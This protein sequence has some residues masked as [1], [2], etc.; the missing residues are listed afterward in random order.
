MS[1]FISVGFKGQWD[2]SGDQGVL[3]AV[4]KIAAE[5][6]KMLEG[7]VNFASTVKGIEAI[8]AAFDKIT[9]SADNVEAAMRATKRA[10]EEEERSVH[11]LITAYKFLDEIAS[12]PRSST[13]VGAQL[14]ME[15]RAKAIKMLRELERKSDDEAVKSWA[16]GQWERQLQTIRSINAEYKRAIE[17]SGALAKSQDAAA[18]AAERIRSEIV[19]VNKEIRKWGSTSLRGEG[20]ERQIAG[21][22]RL[23][24]L[25]KELGD[26][27]S[28]GVAEAAAEVNRYSAR[29]KEL[30]K[31]QAAYGKIAESGST[32]AKNARRAELLELDRLRQEHEK[33]NTSLANV[34][35]DGAAANVALRTKLEKQ[36]QG[37]I[38]KRIELGD[39]TRD[40]LAKEYEQIMRNAS[41]VDRLQQELAI[42]KA[43]I[44][45]PLQSE[46]LLASMQNRI[47][48]IDQA[49]KV[50]EQLKKVGGAD[51][52]TGTKVLADMKNER[53][54][55]DDQMKIIIQDQI[56]EIDLLK[57]E[58][59]VVERLRQKYNALRKDAA[60]GVADKSHGSLLSSQAD[61][62]ESMKTARDLY[63]SGGIDKG[64]Y[65]RE[66]AAIRKQLLLVRAALRDY[67]KQ[68]M[69]AS[70]TSGK[71]VK[72]QV[73]DVEKLRKK[74]QELTATIEKLEGAQAHAVTLKPQYE[75]LRTTL[76]GLFNSKD[77]GFDEYNRLNIE[78]SKRLAEL[79][80]QTKKAHKTWGKSFKDLIKYQF[81]WYLG[82]T[83]LLG[84]GYKLAEAF[85]K[86]FD[87]TQQ[88][89]DAKAVIGATESEFVRMQEAVLNVGKNIAVSAQDAAEAI[90]VL[91]QAGL[92]AEQAIS[93]LDTVAGLIVATGGD[94][95]ET[96]KSV[97]T[98]MNVWN[99]ESDRVAEIGNVMAASLN[100]S[101]LE[102][103]DLGVIFNYLASTAAEVNWT[104]EETSAAAAVLANQGIRVSTIG[105][106]LSSVVSSLIAPTTRM[107]KVFEE[108][109]LTMADLDPRTH[110]FADILEKL[111]EKGFGVEEAFR[112]FN[113]R[114]ARILAA[115]I[116][117]GSDAFREM[118]VNLTGTN[119][120]M[121]MVADSMA[122][123]KR[124]FELL[125]IEIQ[126][127][128]N[129]AMMD[130]ENYVAD[131]AKALRF[132][133]SAGADAIVP[134]T[135]FN[136]ALSLLAGTTKKTAD[137]VSVL[138][139][140]FT[141]IGGFWTL[142]AIAGSA[143]IAI[144]MK[145]MKTNEEYR[146]DLVAQQK[147]EMV[148]AEGFRQ[149]AVAMNDFQKVAEK[150]QNDQ[151]KLAEI[152]NRLIQ[153]DPA[154]IKYLNEQGISASET[155]TSY[156]ALTAAM[157]NYADEMR[158][159]QAIKEQAGWNK[160]A[161]EFGL[162][163]KQL[164]SLMSKQKEYDNYNNKATDSSGSTDMLD[165]PGALQEVEQK[166][167][168]L[169]AETAKWKSL[170][171]ALF[172]EVR[173]KARSLASDP[174]GIISLKETLRSAF[175]LRP[176]V[177]NKMFE[178]IDKAVDEQK[179]K[180]LKI[181]KEEEVAYITSNKGLKKIYAERRTMVDE[182]IDYMIQQ[183]SRSN[184]SESTVINESVSL[185]KRKASLMIGLI[186]EEA[187][188]RMASSDIEKMDAQKK[189]A[190]ISQIQMEASKARMKVWDEM[191]RALTDL[192]AQSM[193]A[194]EY[195]SQVSMDRTQSEYDMKIAG[196]KYKH[197]TEVNAAK[198]SVRLERMKVDD[199]V[200]LA[201][202][203]YESKKR[204]IQK[205]YADE[206][207]RSKA[208]TKLTKESLDFQVDA[209]E[210]LKDK[211]MDF[212]DASKERAK[213]LK[214][215]FKDIQK[216][217]K[218][219]Y[220]MARDTL[221][222]IFGEGNKHPDAILDE[223]GS[224]AEKIQ[225]LLSRGTEEGL[226]EGA[227]LAQKGLSKLGDIDWDTWKDKLNFSELYKSDITSV[228]E[229]L[230]DLYRKTQ[231]ELGH[232]KK[233]Q[234]DK[235]SSLAS[236][237]KSEIDVLEGKINNLR[238]KQINVGVKVDEKQVNETVKKIES[239]KAT[240]EVGVKYT[241]EDIKRIAQDIKKE[242]GGEGKSGIEVPVIPF[243]KEEDLTLLR[244]ELAKEQHSPLTIDPIN[245]PTIEAMLAE[246][247]K[248]VT[249]Y[250]TIVEKRVGAGGGGGSE[251][252]PEEP[253]GD[254]EAM[255]TGGWLPGYG[256]GDRIR[257]LAEAGEFIN[258]KESVSYY[259]KELFDL[260]NS[261]AI[262]RELIYE[263][264]KGAKP[265][266]YAAG[267]MVEHRGAA[268]TFTLAL[269]FG[270][271]DY[272][273]RVLM[274]SRD[275][276]KRFMD[277]Y[278]KENL[279][280]R[281]N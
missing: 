33:L 264:L 98:V 168:D 173:N 2:Q 130:G 175:I 239:K 154:I 132:I 63:Q 276:F 83:L 43:T 249:K 116:N 96:V 179:K 214:D 156:T 205:T 136:L 254:G 65:D 9:K 10:Q 23:K 37:I 148:A 233:M 238:D 166:I 42:L 12:K 218:D 22:E 176:D 60:M 13:A 39:R 113:K 152:K 89:R 224:M 73:S 274:Q 110:S 17:G 188:A 142:A 260:L 273:L 111:Q 86:A 54:A 121:K 161:E 171:D 220:G 46:N 74:Y 199:I 1:E 164:D 143:I 27:G 16:R 104:F 247:A 91:G 240:L 94:M 70:G 78:A 196:I 125:G 127:R 149:R 66:I 97:T 32:A 8:A 180:N 271:G 107:K 41:G 207:E 197:M 3:D 178:Q 153:Q 232:K 5:I 56:K 52:A 217:I 215:E 88:V 256:G 68:W 145:M 246:L 266:G 192:A 141:K 201:K 76:K 34:P 245:W 182:S 190:A 257:I 202:G 135:A 109:G 102:M 55:M 49:I 252:A 230:E 200:G 213:Q 119:A 242:T 270:G 241:P 105:T 265:K 128:F 186:E 163:E 162:I 144:T 208:I 219:S 216:N 45:S 191:N 67:E 158:R 15:N 235:E 120:M 280:R 36:L 211:L 126:N 80:A 281:K 223:V 195:R 139:K 77:M 243:A 181:A 31:V 53:K 59:E 40:D 225:A 99:Y 61:L 117:A 38:L 81:E 210:N 184:Q 228:A 30:Q 58:E 79:D 82:T 234:I 151:E 138:S 187:Q 272:P 29:I 93:S 160:K 204:L 57:K 26:I 87:F 19:Q 277:R 221:S 106:G 131:F 50:A 103:K 137:G 21:Y 269:Q 101:K 170:M 118:T 203:E 236:N 194:L 278:E 167:K 258:R 72:E 229:Q 165:D 140:I 24:V 275:V 92:T 133:V 44:N 62:Q 244:A 112:A 263:A 90:K 193:E 227:E 84:T 259:S 185:W 155:A 115:S 226:T 18:A 279:L 251:S 25:V 209:Y 35:Q 95:N 47:K 231:E 11:N 6:N 262:P 150:H 183:L 14:E 85:Q 206:K 28:M 100:A 69:E 198:E 4:K 124:Q 268:E 253:A 255:A 108:F 123:A 157:K 159:Q 147:D 75:A 172:A 129:R 174:D 261:C 169:S 7:A 222:G 51:G 134:I 114:E 64:V 212:Y 189:E 48:A 122:G 20:V 237:L 177:Y 248:P 146:E 71:V 250:V 267:G